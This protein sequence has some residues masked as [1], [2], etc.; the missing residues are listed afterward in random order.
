MRVLEAEPL[1]V[2]PNG[3]QRPGFGKRVL[4]L[5]GS[6]GPG[7]SKRSLLELIDVLRASDC[8]PVVACPAPGW[9]TTQLQSRGVPFVVVPYFA[10]RKFFERFRV[11]PTI[12]KQWLPRLSGWSFAIVHSNE[13]WWAPHA[14]EL[15]QRLGVPAVVHLRD[16]HHTLKKAR[17]YQ[18]ERAT[19]V[20][21]VS[22][23]LRE[24]FIASPTLYARTRVVFNGH[25]EA[26]VQFSQSQATARRHFG[27]LPDQL[28]IA[29]AG[30]LCER[31]NQR[32][33]LRAASELKRSGR[34]PPFTLLFAGA[35]EPGYAA[36]LREEAAALGIAGQVHWAGPVEDMAAF[37]SA[38]DLI[39]HCALREGLPRVL[40]EA[41]LAGRAVISVQAEGVRD[42]IPDARYGIVV[43]QGDLESMVKG[44]E[45]LG[46]NPS[47]REHLAAQ[48]RERARLLFSTRA[49]QENMRQLYR[50]LT[51]HVPA[52]S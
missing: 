32:L 15:A 4:F 29:N 11:R 14:A 48:A 3:H 40:P 47:L 1:V 6:S 41:M 16:G 2:K 37:Y 22:T 5:Q 26:L 38:S 21:A 7:G 49:H 36:L 39:V 34:L 19:A 46:T 42:A 28:V 50:E 35:A 20:V 52:T 43:S 10:W 51:E 44:I 12:R 23:D 24:R 17:Q 31:K 25:N 33:L 45:E 8:E 30:Q 27:L 9:L 18:L 13:F